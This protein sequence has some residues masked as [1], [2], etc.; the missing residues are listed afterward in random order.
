MRMNSKAAVPSAPLGMCEA[1]GIRS[2]QRS[3]CSE[4]TRKG[5][6][7]QL[8]LLAPSVLCSLSFVPRSSACLDTCRSRDDLF[9]LHRQYSRS[10]LCKEYLRNRPAGEQGSLIRSCTLLVLCT[11]SNS[12]QPAGTGQHL[13]NLGI[14]LRSKTSNALS[15]PIISSEGCFS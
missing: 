14:P 11:V 8:S 7:T 15:L 1:A 10:N 13:G 5:T 4:G 6:G 3:C 9:S 2:H 12:L